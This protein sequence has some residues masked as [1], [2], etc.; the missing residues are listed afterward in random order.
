[1]AIQENPSA[2]VLLDEIEKSSPEVR[3]VMLQLLDEGRLTTNF[4][5]ALDFTNSIVIATSNAGSDFIKSQVER[6]VAAATLEKQLL[7]QL[8]ANRVFAPEFLNRFD[9]VVVYLPLTADEVKEVVKIRL[10]ALAK[11]LEQQKAVTLEVSSAVVNELAKRGYDPV[12]GARALDRVIKSDLETAIARELIS[13]RTPA[14]SVLKVS[15][16]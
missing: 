16:L 5:K 3:N 7:D 13:Q 6:R 2:V 8:I 9:G 4:G 15:S 14:G 1:V 11:L 12:F 10:S